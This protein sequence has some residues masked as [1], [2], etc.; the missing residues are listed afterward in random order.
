MKEI[1][2]LKTFE[3]VLVYFWSEL[4]LSCKYAEQFVDI[5]TDVYPQLKIV[6]INML[7]NLDL[8]T[9]YDIQV[10]PTFLVFKN[11]KL[12]ERIVGFKSGQHEIEKRIRKVIF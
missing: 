11:K 6:K 10:L 9:L 2:E 8:A 4:C 7:S 5:L 3:Y 12:V 1:E